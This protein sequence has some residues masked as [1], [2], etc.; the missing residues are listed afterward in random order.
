[1]NEL[2]AL[3]NELKN[4]KIIYRSMLEKLYSQEISQEEHDKSLAEY[5]SLTS[6]VRKLRSK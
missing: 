1:M 6:K 3:E 5:L 2:K 4:A